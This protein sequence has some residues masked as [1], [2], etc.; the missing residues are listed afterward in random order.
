V[1]F[2]ETNVSLLGRLSCFIFQK[3]FYFIYFGIFNFFVS[4]NFCSF[5]IFLVTFFPFQIFAI[6]TRSTVYRSEKETLQIPNI[7]REAR[8]G[9]SQKLNLVH[10]FRAKEKTANSETSPGTV[11]WAKYNVYF[12]VYSRNSRKSKSVR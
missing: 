8:E 2:Y 12:S 6:S 5:K 11:L 3:L 7:L 1:W 9:Y 4:S 10:C